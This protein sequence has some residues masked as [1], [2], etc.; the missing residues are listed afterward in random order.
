MKN[1]SGVGKTV[2]LGALG[3]LLSVAI[4]AGLVFGIYTVF[5]KPAEFGH[6]V[7][8][9][10]EGTGYYRH[11]Y[12][13]LN[14]NEKLIYSVILKEIYNQPESIEIP[15]ML[16]GDDLSRIF[17]AISHDNPDL[18]GLSLNCSVYTRGYKTYFRPNYDISYNEYA[19][20]LAEVQGVVS[21]IVANAKTYKSIY[22][23]EK[24]V[25]D[26][27]INHCAYEEPTNDPAV[28]TIYGCL[29]LGKASCE[30]YS[31]SFQYIMNQLGVDNRLVTGESAD[32]GVNFV[33]HMWNYVVLDGN[34][35]FVDLT[36]DDPRTEGSVLRHTYFNVT[37]ADINTK[38][39]NIEQQ[40]PLC[41]ATEYNYFIHEAAY[42]NVGSGALFES[43]ISTAV[44]YA[45]Q[46]GQSSF[47]IRFSD[48]AIMAQAK[49][50]LFNSGV[51]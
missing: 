28:N 22:E 33:G 26:Y 20:Q 15:T 35:Y 46:T 2:G 23:Q 8:A 47:E 31:R 44:H 51:I 24:F 48:A 1:K 27:I 25:H 11:N 4:M 42:L 37:T 30:G 29:V 43:K 17:Q 16:P 19:S 5:L 38:H 12:E 9:S 6:L 10:G 41:T 21:S 7:P 45:V 49:I 40:L 50:T 18:F 36:W 13:D 3:L 32:D 34:G 14:E 39:R